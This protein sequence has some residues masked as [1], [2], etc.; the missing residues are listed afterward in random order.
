MVNH[1]KSKGS[2]RVGMVITV[3]ILSLS[4]VAFAQS[5]NL[6]SQVVVGNAAPTVSGVLINNGSNITLTAN[7]TTAVTVYYQVQDANGCGDVLYNGGVTTT[8]WR[9]G[10][11]STCYTNGT[12]SSLN[13]Y[14][15]NVTSTN[16]CPSA[17]SAVTT[18]N[19]T[20]TFQI[21]YFAQATDA[22]SSFSSQWWG[23]YVAARDASNASGTNVAN[24]TRTLIT[25]AAIN[26]TTSSINYGTI[27]AN[28]DSGATD[29]ITTSTNAG[30]C[31]TTLK[32]Y[33]SSTLA[34]GPNSI[35]TSS[36]RY[37][38]SSFTYPGTST[39]ITGAAT[40]VGGF[41]LTAPTSTT[42][43]TQPLYWG[44]A[45]PNG[46]PTGTYTGT[47]VFLPSWTP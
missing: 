4:T 26:V 33:A 19:V 42:N 45:V 8:L 24:A 16:D 43:I 31:T 20:T 11:S 27:A 10:V 18:A 28:S 2:V 23:A 13:C 36:Q 39:Q 22:S 30:N 46:T 40:F 38:T 15:T 21:W 25:L 32:V 29:Q 7:T 3:A 47:N 41:S 9:S 17:T 34:S 6:T 12:T 37:S 35:T 1:K 5:A 44:L 14:V